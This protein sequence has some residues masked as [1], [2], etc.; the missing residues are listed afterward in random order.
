MSEA[1]LITSLASHTVFSSVSS[2]SSST[3]PAGIPDWRLNPWQWVDQ[4]V[5]KSQSSPNSVSWSDQVDEFFDSK[6]QTPGVCSIPG[7]QIVE[8]SQS[9]PNSVSWSDQVDEFF[10]SKLQTPGV[11]HELPSLN[12]TPV[13][14]LQDGQLVRFRAMVQDNFE[15]ELYLSQFRVRDLNSGRI[16][17]VTSKYRDLV[18]CGPREELLSDESD[19]VVHGERQSFYCVSVPGEAAW[20]A[21]GF[22]RRSDSASPIPSTSK[23]G[24]HL[25]RRNTV[26]DAMEMAESEESSK[27]IRTQAH[28]NGAASDSTTGSNNSLS[29]N[30]PLPDAQGKAA[31]IKFYN[32][33]ASFSINDVYE[34]V[35][36]I[37]LDPSLASMPHEGDME[38]DYFEQ[39]NQQERLVQSPPPSLI[40]RL[41]VI[42]QKVVL[43]SNPNLT[44]MSTVVPESATESFLKCRDSL[45]DIL[46][47]VLLGDGLAADYLM[48]HLMAKIYKRQHGLVL[49]KFALNVFAVPMEQ[50]YTH[51]LT[52]F[53]QQLISKSHYLALTIEALNKLSFFPKKDHHANRLISGMLQLS[54]HTHLILDETKMNQGQLTP[55]G[56][57]N[58]KAL[59]NLIS[60]QKV[61]YDFSFH[62]LPFESDCP[63]LILSEGRTMLPSDFQLLLKPTVEVTPAS[64]DESLLSANAAL[65]SEILT[66]LRN[67]L[68]Q[69]RFLDWKLTADI[70]AGIEQ[71]FVQL[72][73]EDPTKFTPEDL[74]DH[75]VLAKL[76]SQSYGLNNLD[77]HVWTKVKAMELERK[78]RLVHLPPRNRN[79][80]LLGQE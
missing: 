79:G 2:V 1:Q 55:E 75:L 52:T 74:H 59:G 25:K 63:C 77:H 58:L 42:K 28:P 5:E 76:M 80:G 45:H 73:A 8:K 4:I 68:T 37:S 39:F 56:L 17:W 61:D 62:Q 34:F 47:K 43:H 48:C 78:E 71:D 29:L 11:W 38:Q 49:G 44:E 50:N 26:D 27:R 51:R 10:D 21:E 3:M 64:I 18:A 14:E 70:E 46:K 20:A 7:H 72:R 65:S 9:S 66:H 35:G 40:P 23:M 53:L 57:N 30:L 15:T 32:S 6:L 24:N 31:I 13:H 67:F 12:D 19:Q 22:R 16:R 54:K 60:W 69:A 33:N 41:H 36:I